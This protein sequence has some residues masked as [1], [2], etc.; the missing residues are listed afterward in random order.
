MSGIDFFVTGHP[1]GQPRA[2]AFAVKRGAD[3]FVRMYDPATA[4]AWKNQIAAVARA[5][6]PERPLVGPVQVTLEFVMP[7]PRFHSHQTGR[8]AGM[9]RTNAPHWHVGKPDADN[10]AKAVL[11]ALTTLGFFGDDA[12][13]ADLWVRKAYGD[14]PG[15]HVII[16]SL[17]PS[18]ANVKSAA[19][20]AL[21]L[22]CY[23]DDK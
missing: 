19:Q 7:R 5:V 10:L 23:S 16:E 4:E 20:P 14:A 12:Q 1:K 11:D 18:E 15:C 6:L 8:H 3:T 9:L 22:G 13:I 2:R 21:A 17:T